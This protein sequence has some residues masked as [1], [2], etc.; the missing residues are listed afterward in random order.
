ML[1]DWWIGTQN[2]AEYF[3][4]AL[5]RQGAESENATSVYRP[6]NFFHVGWAVLVQMKKDSALRD[7]ETPSARCLGRRSKR[8]ILFS[9][10]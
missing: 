4:W 2:E 9:R 10:S 1:Y 6:S 5:G 7:T 3:N 8:L